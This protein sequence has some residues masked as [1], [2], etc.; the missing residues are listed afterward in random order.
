[1]RLRRNAV[2]FRSLLQGLEGL[3]QLVEWAPETGKW[4]LLLVV[5]HLAD[6]ERDDFKVRLDH[7]LHKSGAA[8]PDIDPEG[9][10]TSRHYAAQSFEESLQRFLAERERS[11]T[12]LE[13]LRSPDWTMTH[14]HARL[15]TLSAGDLMA[16]WVDHDHQ[17]MRQILNLLHGS[18]CVETAPYETHYAGEW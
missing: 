16:A 6:E 7:T 5:N 13:G 15:G 2:T 17:H 9:W 12:W 3:G 10:V 4:S 18:L 11:V 1:M 8:W 14:D